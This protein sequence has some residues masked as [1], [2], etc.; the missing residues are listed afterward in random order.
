M[1]R[2]I[3]RL[4]WA[5][6]VLVLGMGLGLF[7]LQRW[8]ASDDFRTRV[9]AQAE[10]TLGVPV[11]LGRLQVDAWPVPAVALEAVE[12]RT[13]P[14]L[15]A[16]RIGLR[17]QLSELLAGRLSVASLVVQGA[18]LPQAGIDKLLLA[19]RRASRAA[20]PAEQPAAV[21]TPVETAAR[22]LLLIPRSLTLD[23]VIW[24][25]N[26]GEATTLDG[27]ATL[28]FSGLPKALDIRLRAGVFE[29]AQFK[30]TRPAPG[31]RTPGKLSW[32]IHVQ[33][34]GGT[35][36]GDLT[37]QGPTGDAATLSVQG[38]FETRNLELGALRRGTP[39]PLGG[40]LRASTTVSAKAAGTAA[41]AQAL[42]SQSTFTVDNA[43]VRGI[44]LARAVQTVGLSR[45][46]QTRL[47]TL[48]GQ[49]T[50]RGQAIEL[51]QI[52]ASSGALSATGDVAVA[53]NRSL[54]G[55]IHVNLAEKVVGKAVGVPLEVGGTLDAPT[56]TLTRGAMLGAAIGT[57]VMPGVGTGAGASVGEAI[58]EKL[59][60]LFGK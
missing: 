33:H 57:L 5:L 37:V 38:Q 8:V 36:T 26:R 58:G 32:D 43:V 34:A 59:R 27:V 50:T 10:T 21:P 51:R 46:G 1:G 53:P 45:G 20:A 56:V 30:A 12:V 52:A 18:D 19:M 17:L 7:A 23:D 40:R 4:F 47:D 54:S 11:V 42:V 6:L 60:G 39:G 48:S 3:K 25:S 41:L 35:I 16:R 29:G 31:S 24:R 49:L 22:P 55:R 2:L 15:T 14:A 28:D 13:Q 44:D 9:Q